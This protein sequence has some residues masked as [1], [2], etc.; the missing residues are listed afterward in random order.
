MNVSYR[1]W[2]FLLCLSW[3]SIPVFA[4]QQTGS[5]PVS[6]QLQPGLA[7]PPT[8]TD[9][10]VVLDVVVTD[11]SGMATKGLEEKDFTVLDNGQPRKILSF[12]AVGGGAVATNIQPVEPPVK[13]I[14]LV[15]EVNTNF[16][17]V[18]Y[19]RSQIKMFL[20][21]NGGMLAHPVSMAFFTDKGAEVQEMSTRD[22]NALLQVFDEHET[23]LR[24]IRRSEGFYGAVEKFQLSLTTLSL[25]ANK[26]V[27]VPGRK[28][29]V[30]ISPGWP[31][32]SGPG[33][34][35]SAKA[36]AS[37]FASIVSLSTAMRDARMTLYSIDPQGSDAGTRD[38]Y[39]QDF[40]KPVTVAKKSLPGN[41]A[42]QVLAV[43]SGGLALPASNDI[44]GQIARCVADGDSYYTLTV[45]AAPADQP[46]VYHALTVKV[47]TPGLKVRTRDGYYTQP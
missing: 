23:A 19:E 14:L 38:F 36:V 44:T 10:P 39:Y 3:F 45:D 25:L 4:Q 27:E 5:A 6:G 7:S 47:A 16:D 32:L 12:Q 17:R 29:V 15:D 24:S 18:S 40:L 1:A 22:G 42:L 9:H 28:M 43:Q 8:A 26:Q 31:L 46:N 30:W 34:D 21:Q 11:K 33:V 13:I 20:Q 35:L 2:L 37:L 41:L